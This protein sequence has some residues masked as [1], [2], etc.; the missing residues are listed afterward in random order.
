V[1]NNLIL[2]A[3][4]STLPSDGVIYSQGTITITGNLTLPAGASP[5]IIRAQNSIIVS[6]GVTIGPGITLQIQSFLP[7]CDNFSSA[8]IT[9]VTVDASFC[10]SSNYQANQA[11]LQKLN[12]PDSTTGNSKSAIDKFAIG[13]YPNPANSQCTV[14]FTISDGADVT[15]TLIDMMGQE[16]ATIDHS[17]HSQGTSFVPFSTSS[18]APGI[19]TVRFSDGTNTSTQ[20]LTISGRD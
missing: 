1:P 6:P 16:V 12:I 10:N 8:A 14:K 19:Y 4:P 2:S 7:I 17:W 11:V 3:L 15:I 20:R 5:I 13:L 9:P 18:Y